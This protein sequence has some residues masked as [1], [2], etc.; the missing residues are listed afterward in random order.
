M[1]REELAEGME[2][3]MDIRAK[4][5]TLL[6]KRGARMNSATLKALEQHCRDETS[7]RVVLVYARDDRWV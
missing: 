4:G 6:L 7:N 5:G 1:A 2:L 3:A